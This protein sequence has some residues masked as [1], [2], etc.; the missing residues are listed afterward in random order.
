MSNINFTFPN[1][2]RFTSDSILYDSI[3]NPD[4][5]NICITYDNQNI[6]FLIDSSGVCVQFNIKSRDFNYI[7]PTPVNT[8][9]INSILKYNDIL[10]GF[11]GYQATKFVDN[12]VFYILDGNKLV[13]ESFDGV[14]KYIHL[15]SDTEI[16]DF[17]I[18]DEYNYYVIHNTNKISKFTKDRI[19]VYSIEIKNTATNYFYDIGVSTNATIDL[20]KMD[21]VREYTPNGLSAYPIVLGSVSNTKELFLMKLYD[22][23]TSTNEL[24][25]VIITTPVFLKDSDGNTLSGEYVAFGDPNRLNYNLSNYE[26]LKRT[27]INYDQMLFKLTLK[28]EYNNEDYY[29][30][31]IPISTEPFTTEKH[32]LA[33]RLDSIN[34]IISVYL[35]GKRI[36]DQNIKPGQFLFQ[37]VFYE[38]MSIGNTYYSNKNTLDKYLN[39]SGYYYCDN[40]QVDQFKMYDKILTDNEINF[41]ILDNTE[42]DDLIV[43]LPT[44]QRNAL[45]GIERQFKLDVSGSKSNKFNIIVKNSGIVNPILKEQMSQILKEKLSKYIPATSEIYN[46]EFRN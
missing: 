18:D 46:I 12:T 44:G 24:S 6:Y 26:Y 20:I 7:T 43:S 16:R 36:A 8:T 17:F 22:S 2:T 23:P 21:Y 32:H 10:Y 39:Q 19:P 37:N 35:D 14:V 42:V 34:G 31:L 41:V 33:F 3:G 15:Q 45:D 28:N 40:F 9:S 29:D 11:A 25:S 38:G 5:N 27:Y 30:I 1:I 4:I 13:Q